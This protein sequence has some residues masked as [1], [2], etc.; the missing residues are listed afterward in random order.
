MCIINLFLFL[1]LILK[2]NLRSNYVVILNITWLITSYI[3]VRE[4]KYESN[5]GEHLSRVCYVLKLGFFLF[6]GREA[7]LFAAL[8]WAFFHAGI[9]PTN[10]LGLV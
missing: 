2:I 5:L 4:I 6:V 10:D 8:F 9:V 7:A 1:A 3:Y